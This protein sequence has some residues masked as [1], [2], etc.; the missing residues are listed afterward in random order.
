MYKFYIGNKYASQ[1]IC[2]N[3]IQIGYTNK[4]GELEQE[5]N[6]KIKLKPS[7]SD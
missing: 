2:L 6:T 1:N 3:E 7:S 4:E 5:E